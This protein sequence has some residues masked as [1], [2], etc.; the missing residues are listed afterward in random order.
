VPVGS[1]IPNAV[2][3]KLV[4]SGSYELPLPES[5]GRLSVGATFV[6]TSKYRAVS[7]PPVLATLVS[8]GRA[9]VNT[10]IN[11]FNCGR[12][13]HPHSPANTASCP[14]RRCLTSTS[15]GTKSAERRSMPRSSS[16][17]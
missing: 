17:T 2:P 8:P 12:P 4:L 15:T 1:P 10:N 14:A 6:Y 11:L 13:R 7:D 5:V 9:T 3:H 16:P